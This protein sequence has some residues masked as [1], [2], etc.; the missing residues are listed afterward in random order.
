MASILASPVPDVLIFCA[1]FDPAILLVCHA[2]E[3]PVRQSFETKIGGTARCSSCGPAH[4]IWTL[5]Y[6]WLS[7]ARR[8]GRSGGL[9]ARQCEGEIRAAGACTFAVPYRRCADFAALRLPRATGAFAKENRRCSGRNFVVPAAGRARHR[10]DEQA[11]RLRT[12]R[13][14]DGHGRS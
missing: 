11:A 6:L 10:L 13:R 14:R 7:G 4:A 8:R 12:A 5:H 9:G 1:T 3:N 2:R